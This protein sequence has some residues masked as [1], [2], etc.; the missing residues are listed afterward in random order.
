MNPEQ[1]PR[2]RDLETANAFKPES[3]RAKL[4]ADLFT[5]ATGVAEEQGNA[6][7]GRAAWEAAQNAN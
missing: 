4:T 2:R 3:T 7:A 1:Q 5:A 6:E